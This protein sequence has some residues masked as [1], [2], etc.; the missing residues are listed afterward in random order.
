[1]ISARDTWDDLILLILQIF[2]FFSQAQIA[3]IPFGRYPAIFDGCS[4]GAIRLVG[5]STITKLAAGYQWPDFPVIRIDLG[6]LQIEQGQAADTRRI[7]H[8]PAYLQGNKFDMARGMQ[9]FPR[10]FADFF[11]AQTQPGL[12]G[13]EQARFAHAGRTGE[14]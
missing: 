3:V 2:L 14:D 8:I 11:H 10:G 5:M 12:N 7:S 6:W 13:V 4:H 1:M 9:S